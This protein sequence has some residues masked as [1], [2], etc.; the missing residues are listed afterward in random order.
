MGKRTMVTAK[1]SV[2]K[3]MMVRSRRGKQDML[4][5]KLMFMIM[6]ACVNI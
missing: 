3:R 6:N 5:L 1:T 2:K 4:L